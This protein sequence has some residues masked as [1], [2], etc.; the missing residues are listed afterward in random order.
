MYSDRSICFLHI[1]LGF[2]IQTWWLNGLISASI[3]HLFSVLGD[4]GHPSILAVGDNMEHIIRC[5]T[6]IFIP[7]V[8]SLALIHL[9]HLGKRSFVKLLLRCFLLLILS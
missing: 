8:T 5:Q 2:I 1:L 6:T 4:Q 3:T 9:L 7:W